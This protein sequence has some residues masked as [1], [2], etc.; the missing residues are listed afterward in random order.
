MWCSC[1]VFYSTGRGVS[2]LRCLTPRPGDNYSISWVLPCSLRAKVS[3]RRALEKSW[4]GSG[5]GGTRL[6]LR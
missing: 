5:E 2:P 4:G 3:N 1:R 6:V